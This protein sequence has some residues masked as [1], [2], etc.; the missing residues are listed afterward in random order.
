MLTFCLVSISGYRED[1]ILEMAHQRVSTILIGSSTSVFICLFV[2]PVWAGDDLHNLVASSLEKL[3]SFLEGMFIVNWCIKWKI[4]HVNI[5][6][7]IRFALW[8]L[9]NLLVLISKTQIT[10]FGVEYFKIPGDSKESNNTFMD[11][12]KSVL[13]SK[14]SEECLVRRNK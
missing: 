14:Q 7:I 5:C 12:Y 10:G 6:V 1:E 8:W 9:V 3:G 11:D 4:M 13:N 2:F